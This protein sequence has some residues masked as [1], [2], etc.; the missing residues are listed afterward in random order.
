[1]TPPRRGFFTGQGESGDL[2]GLQAEASL[3]QA[4]E[5]EQGPRWAPWGGQLWPLSASKGAELVGVGK[6]RSGVM[7]EK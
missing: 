5:V 2:G 4:P 3:S 7:L 1:M 6:A